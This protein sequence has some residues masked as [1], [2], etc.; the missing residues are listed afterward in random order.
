M[1]GD[2]ECIGA[3]GRAGVVIQGP[4]SRPD[5]RG[6]PELPDRAHWAVDLLTAPEGLSPA[7]ARALD[8][9]REPSLILAPVRGTPTHPLVAWMDTP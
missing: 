9:M 2:V 4:R 5:R 8:L 7:L 1:A 3:G 6:W